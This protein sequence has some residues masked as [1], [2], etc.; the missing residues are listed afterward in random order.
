MI[1]VGI[2][3]NVILDKAE[4]TDPEKG[5]LTLTFRGRKSPDTVELSAFEALGSDGYTDTSADS[6]SIKILSPLPPYAQRNDGT[7]IPLQDQQAS[8]IDSIAE[9]KNLLYQIL[10][11]YMVSSAI[12][13]DL[14]KGT[15]LNASNFPQRIIEADVLCK[16]MFNMAT[17][18]VN[19]ITPF[20]G[21]DELP[22]RLLLVRQSK[23]KHFKDFRQRFV[24]ENPVI[25]S[26]LIPKEA[27]KL[28]FTKYEIN[29]GLNSGAVTEQAAADAV[30]DKAEV[31]QVETVF[32]QQ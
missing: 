18:F 23:T 31:L 24:K 22:V 25:E 3:E 15:G 27:S 13:F 20:L 28:A 19:L 30:A 32:G 7:P 4:I 11:V 17:D 5:I 14:Y 9:K 2:N 12:K 8:A 6:T 21:K 16:V 29:N 10:S 26:M 1:E